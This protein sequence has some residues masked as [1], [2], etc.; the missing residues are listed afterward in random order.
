MLHVTTGQSPSHSDDGTKGTPVLCIPGRPYS[1]DSAKSCC[2]S[3]YFLIKQVAAYIR[4]YMRSSA[5]V[6]YDGSASMAVIISFKD[7]YDNVSVHQ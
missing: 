2:S 7:D 3:K 6:L 5:S 4:D 1:M